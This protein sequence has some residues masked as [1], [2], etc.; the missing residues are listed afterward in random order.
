MTNG[1]PWGEFF[2]KVERRTIW[3]LTAVVTALFLAGW[4]IT[5]YLFKV[6]V[7]DKL[8]RGGFH[9]WTL[10]VLQLM[11]GISTLA[12]VGVPILGDIAKI[13]LRE[14]EEVRR[15]R[16]AGKSNEAKNR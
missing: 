10:G 6:F 16:E 11:F 9:P 5:Q 4:A 7:L 13:A 15:E 12:A 2:S 1:G 14:W 8:E 3:F